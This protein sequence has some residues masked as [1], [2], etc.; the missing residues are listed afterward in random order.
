MSVFR[1]VSFLVPG[2]LLA[3]AYSDSSSSWLEWL[4]AIV[5]LGFSV[6]AVRIVFWE[7]LIRWCFGVRPLFGTTKSAAWSLYAAYMNLTIA[8]VCAPPKF[9]SDGMW[10]LVALFSVASIFQFGVYRGVVTAKQLGAT[11]DD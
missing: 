2:T 1:W 10:I 8:L 5:L 6:D 3:N 11:V 7:W 4:I 9:P